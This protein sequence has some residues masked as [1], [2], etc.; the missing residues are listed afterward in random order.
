L[1]LPAATSIEYYSLTLSTANPNAI[2][3][4]WRLLGSTD[5]SAWQQIDAFQFQTATPP[6]N[7]WKYAQMVLPLAIPTANV[8]AYA[9]YRLVVEATFGET[10]AAIS[11]VDLFM[12]NAKTATLD[13]REKPVVLKNNVLYMNRF[14]GQPVYRLGDLSGNSLASTPRN[15][16]EYVNTRVYGV[17]N[18]APVSATCFDGEH[19]FVC[20]ASGNAAYLSNDAAN[21]NLNFD[22]SYNGQ[23][24]DSRLSAIY[25]ACWNRRYVL[26]GGEEGITYGRLDAGTQWTATNA[27][28]LFSRVNGV[29]SNGG[30]GP[31]YIPNTVYL[32]AN[33]TLRVVGPKAYA[34]S[35]EINLSMNAHNAEVA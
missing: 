9:Y 22:T 14:P 17:S 32:R 34:F 15:G 2:P 1:Q 3:K 7:T 24:I 10:Y 35:G 23:P 4:Q 11:G 19:M 8:A 27:G 6:D 25:G 12:S 21:G 31:V 28:Q 16:G 33:N 18:T 20:D 30:Y 13:I 29:A 5:G 26:F